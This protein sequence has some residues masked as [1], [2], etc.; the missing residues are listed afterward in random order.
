[1]KSVSTTVG[2]LWR[3]SIVMMALLLLL[4]GV[5]QV[6]AAPP[7]PT[8]LP[9][10]TVQ[11]QADQPSSERE[12]S[13]QL[14]LS[15]PALPGVTLIQSVPPTVTNNPIQIMAT[16]GHWTGTTGQNRPMS[17]DVLAGGNQW[18]NFRVQAT[19]SNCNVLLTYTLY[20]PG[21]INNN[22]F[23]GVSSDGVF[24]F[25]GRFNSASTASG[26]YNFF[27]ISI[28]GCGNRSQSGTWTA[29][30]PLPCEDAF[31]PDNSF[32]SAKSISLGAAQAHTFHTV[33]DEDWVKFSMTAGGSYTI[34]TSNLGPTN[35]T[36]LYLYDR[37]GTTIL[38]QNDDVGPGQLNSQI[39][40]TANTSGLYYVRVRYLNGAAGG[41]SGYNY[42]LMVTAGP[43]TPTP[44][45]SLITNAVSS[46]QVNLAW[47]DNSNNESGF[48]VERSANGVN[49]LFHAAVGAN[50]INY[51]DTTNL[52]PGATYFYQVRAYNAAGDSAPSNQASVT[53]PNTNNP[54]T[55]TLYLPIIRK[56][57]PPTPT[58][59][60]SPGGNN[61]PAFPNPLQTQI[62]TQFQY[63]SL[64]QLVGAVT[65]IT[66]APAVDPDHDPLT[67]SWT[68]SNG[69]IS[70]NGVTA[71][72]NRVIEF[73]R[74]KAGNVTVV[75]RDGRGGSDSVI[76]RFQ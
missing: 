70:G 54:I 43:S 16:N 48:K 15:A 52:V 26:T 62:S 59:T 57:P 6:R 14:S 60:P 10:T 74:V 12:P 30:V 29:N 4:G 44:P 22:Q 2:R 7:E 41:C 65:T 35:D 76:I 69:S 68:A 73:G 72:W 31:E 53:I 36:Y 56:D 63:N 8:V 61:S 45:S 28:P 67:Y 51:A 13:N 25:S 9:T 21:S 3:V 38:A 66:I 37:N 23:S 34:V 50:T 71:T 75:V 42:N 64:G 19:F 49:W 47:Q 27:N 1:M 58:P 24:A 33:G 5:Y 40:W 39:V 55:P 17:F 20:G 46:S 18:D 32:T 11:P